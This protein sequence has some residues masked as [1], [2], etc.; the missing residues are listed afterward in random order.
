MELEATLQ[1]ACSEHEGPCNEHGKLKTLRRTG[2]ISSAPVDSIWMEMWNMPLTEET[3]T[4]SYRRPDSAG[5]KHLCMALSHAVM[6][7]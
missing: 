5:V 7:N 2:L 3:P 4:A 6:V 1:K